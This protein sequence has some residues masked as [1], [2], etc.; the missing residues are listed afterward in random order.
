MIIA[1]GYATPDFKPL[2]GRFRMKHT[3]VL[4]TRPVSRRERRT[5]GV[6]DVLLWDT[7]RPYHYVRWTDEGRLLFGGGDRPLVSPARRRQA[8]VE[9][10]ARLREQFAHLLP[11]SKDIPI[12]RAWEGVFAMTPDGLPCIGTH[13]RYP[14]HLFALGYGGNGMT[15]GFLAA[16]LL[17]DALHGVPNPDLELFAFNR[18]RRSVRL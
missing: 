8:F 2:I 12:A 5:L 6:G 13:R 16:R 3:Y 15:F 10:T 1:T 17:L 4:A 7:A 11:G 14:R 18:F 9:G